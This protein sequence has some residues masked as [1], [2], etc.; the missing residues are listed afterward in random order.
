M[1]VFLPFLL[2]QGIGFITIKK[3][4]TSTQQFFPCQ[5][6]N[7]DQKKNLD[8]VQSQNHNNETGQFG[9]IFNMLYC[10]YRFYT[11]PVTKF[12]VYMVGFGYYF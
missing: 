2:I 8:P 12:L 6:K 9:W 10:A 1:A 5:K 7:A 3:K 4:K 11:A